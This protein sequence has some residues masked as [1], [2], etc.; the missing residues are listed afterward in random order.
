MSEPER[1]LTPFLWL[2]KFLRSG[3]STSANQQLEDI[4]IWLSYVSFDHG[5]VLDISHWKDIFN[6]LLE[7]GFKNL[8]NVNIFV[9]ALEGHVVDKAVEML[10]NSVYVK[11]LRA[12][13][14]LAVNVRSKHDIL[15]IIIFWFLKK[16]TPAHNVPSFAP[17]IRWDSYDL[18]RWNY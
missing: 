14:N 10:E 12:R 4:T 16:P 13:A 18:E 5:V 1:T 2:S 15:L 9:D 6:M 3:Y 8:R 11:S 17:D 7:D